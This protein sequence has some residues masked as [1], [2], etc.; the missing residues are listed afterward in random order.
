MTVI[1]NDPVTVQDT[2]DLADRALALAGYVLAFGRITRTSCEHPDGTL[3]S[4]TDHTVML[5]WIAPALA[6]LLYPELD[7]GL[8][9]QFAVVHDAVEVFAGDTP[10]L[11]IDAAGLAAKA[12]REA[13]AVT[14]WQD[15]FGSSLPWLPA[16]IARYERQDEPESR[17]TR[18]ADKVLPGLVHLLCGC[19]DLRRYGMTAVQAEQ[20]AATSR[21]R[22]C[23][24]A[25]E[26][27]ALIG[28][29][30]EIV[31]RILAVMREQEAVQ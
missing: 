3:E 17:F 29:R 19:R 25:G 11:R 1:R 21:E 27:T 26:F 22:I 10:T 7:A 4:D 9:A 14:R 24:Y 2:A 31:R 5:A 12:E 6:A 30:D 23:S 18:A 20:G 15:L 13:A 28:L 16:M 8:V